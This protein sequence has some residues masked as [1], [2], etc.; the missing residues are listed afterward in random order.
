M[1]LLLSSSVPLA[2]RSFLD[3]L[4][5][6]F[7]KEATQNYCYILYQLLLFFFLHFVIGKMQILEI[8]WLLLLV[9]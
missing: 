7:R 9:P 6:A 4:E 2:N 8:T 1:D 3:L 5:V